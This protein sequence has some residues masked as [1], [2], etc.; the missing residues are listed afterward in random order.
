MAL[1][2]WLAELRD[3]L[4]AAYPDGP[5]TFQLATVAADG[6]PRVRTVVAR[7]VGDGGAV[8]FVSDRRSAK[9]GEV[10]AD[11]RA[12]ACFW[13]EKPR[14]QYRLRGTVEVTGADATGEDADARL[15]AWRNLSGHGRA[16]FLWPPCGEPRV[17]P[18]GAFVET[19]AD[20]L[21]PPDNFELLTLRPAHVDR[22]DL[23]GT[24]HRRRMW[25]ASDGWAG[26]DVNP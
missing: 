23:S 22:L 17:E 16:L 19:V 10:R 12:S 1:P 7:S 9:D 6:S 14:R 25:S 4:A 18:D 20:T 26:A 13:L 8:A 2:D 24:P 3:G 15:A 5:T 11:P 21:D